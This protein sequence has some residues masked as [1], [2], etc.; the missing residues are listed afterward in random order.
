MRRSFRK[1]E[2]HHRYNPDTGPVSDWSSD[3]VDSMDIVVSE[4]YFARE[5]FQLQMGFSFP[6][7]RAKDLRKSL[8]IVRTHIFLLSFM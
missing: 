1:G 6:F 4:Y 2:N 5:S 3:M 7:L 8:L